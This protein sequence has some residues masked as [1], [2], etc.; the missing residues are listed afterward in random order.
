MW[1]IQARFCVENIVSHRGEI[2]SISIKNDMLLTGCSDGMLRVWHIDQKILS[3]KLSSDPNP[4]SNESKASEISK[5]VSFKGS[6]ERQSNDKILK[7]LFHPILDY[8]GVLGSEKS[9]ELFKIRN[10]AEMS[11]LLKRKQKKAIKKGISNTS[12][13][14]IFEKIIHWST[15]RGGS[16]VKS[17]D[18][19][20]SLSKSTLR[21]FLGMANNSI[22]IY[23]ISIETS[24][25]LSELVNCIELQGHRSDIRTIS[26]NEDDSLIASGSSDRLKIYSADSQIC[27]YTISS[28]YAL[29][30]CF[31]PGSKHV[32][33][34]TKMG[35]LQLFELS[36][37]SMIENIK[38]HDGPIWSMD[39][40]PD[41]SGLITGSE[42]KQ[43]KFWSFSFLHDSNYSENKKRVTLIHTK[44]LKLS[45]DVLSVRVSP[46]G[47]LLAVALL[48]LTVKVFYVDS[49]KFFL[50]LYGHK[51]PV[52]SMD[53]SFD[54][55]II[56]TA[57]SDK[58]VKIWG[59]DFGDCHRSLLAHQDAVMSC[60]FV[61]GTYYFFTA[62][63]DRTIKYFDGEK[64]FQ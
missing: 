31:L 19:A 49:L 12:E 26:L 42:D 18:F 24:N 8:I 11:K 55:R 45:D 38:A 37:S 27:L 25:E 22:E 6:I 17:F 60:R 44:T 14:E 52:V 62:S 63:K 13:I 47:Q 20:T 54:S 36:S 51:L 23:D 15:I 34:G 59:L 7:I 43:V 29:C 33:I 64:V 32:V 10:D 2:W 53:I 57:S 41:K 5:A 39:S 21:L 1:D 48:D 35:E 30:C 28:G 50:S 16:K 58:T 56:I 9:I 61:W 40:L 46:N 3:S 4:A